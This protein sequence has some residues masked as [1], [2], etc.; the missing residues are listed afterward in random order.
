MSTPTDHRVAVV[1]RLQVVLH[2]CGQV[3]ENPAP[4]ELAHNVDGGAHQQSQ[5]HQAEGD[6]GNQRGRGIGIPGRFCGRLG[7]GVLTAGAHE[8]RQT[9]AH[10]AGKV[11]VTRATVVAGEVVAGAGAHGA[12]LAGETERACAGEVVDAVDAGAG[13]AAGVAGAVVN[14]GLAA[15][16]G[17]ARPAAAHDAF[18]EVKTLSAC[19]EGETE[20]FQ[21]RT[22][23]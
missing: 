7:D 10:R 19:R 18:A 20:R 9:L 16:A 21:L 23:R 5:R 11:G 1:H 4:T 8:A 14:V 13:V 2:R 3:P 15:S 22:Q 17:E 6:S 12:V